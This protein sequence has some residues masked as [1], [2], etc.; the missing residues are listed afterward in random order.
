MLG[1]RPRMI[2]DLTLG[3]GVLGRR[4]D[5]RSTSFVS[6]SAPS[7]LAVLSPD[8]VGNFMTERRQHLI[9]RVAAVQDDARLPVPVLAEAV[10]TQVCV[11]DVDAEVS[12][13]VQE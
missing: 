9:S 7:S 10:G 1:Q 2:S 11:V 4:D 5:Q 3:R 8:G 6:S 13:V 12:G